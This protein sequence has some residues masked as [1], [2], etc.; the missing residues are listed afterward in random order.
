MDPS[1]YCH[2]KL[3]GRVPIAA[4]RTHRVSRPSTG[5]LTVLLIPLS[6]RNLT[7]TG[8]SRFALALLLLRSR[9]ALS[10]PSKLHRTYSRFAPCP[11]DQGFH[12]ASL[13]CINLFSI[14]RSLS[15]ARFYLLASA[16]LLPLASLHSFLWLLDQA[17]DRLVSSSSTRC[18]AYT[19]DLST[20]SSSRGLTSF[21]CGNSFLQVGFTLRCLQRLSLPHFA[22]QLCHW[23]D[24]CCTRGASIP[25]LSY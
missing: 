22:S 24:N 9:S 12:V 4:A 16:C 23:H 8:V 3:A 11:P 14:L 5:L 15:L 1:G 19:D 2:R 21:C 20:L 7:P 6:A 13:F 18:R 25:V 10:A 17:L